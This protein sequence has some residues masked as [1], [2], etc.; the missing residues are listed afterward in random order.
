[1]LGDRELPRAIEHVLDVLLELDS[2]QIARRS[3][4]LRLR[5][6]DPT[7]LQHVVYRVKLVGVEPEAHVMRRWFSV[8]VQHQLVDELLGQHAMD[9]RN[10]DRPFTYCRCHALD[11]AAP[12][13]AHGEHAR[14]RSFEQIR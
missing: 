4:E 14:K 1:M 2:R 12:N 13:V 6:F 8:C 11:V 5:G 9:K 3:G 7:R 10:C